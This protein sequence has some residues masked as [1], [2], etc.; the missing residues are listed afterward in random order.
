MGNRML[1]LKV[2]TFQVLLLFVSQAAYAA[3][4]LPLSRT[5]IECIA[6]ETE[7]WAHNGYYPDN[8]ALGQG[9]G[10]CLHAAI[11]NS[12]RILMEGGES[13]ICITHWTCVNAE[14][15]FDRPGHCVVEVTQR[16]RCFGLGKPTNK[17]ISWG[18]CYDSLDDIY[19]N[20]PALKNSRIDVRRSLVDCVQHYVS[21][22]GYFRVDEPPSGRRLK[23]RVCAGYTPSP[24]DCSSAIPKGLAA[25]SAVATASRLTSAGMAF[26]VEAVGA[27]STVEPLVEATC[28]A[29]GMSSE[30]YRL[31]DPVHQFG[32]AVS[33]YCFDD[34]R[35]KPKRDASYYRE[36]LRGLE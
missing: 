14:G 21:D 26:S 12:S 1:N 36:C 27:Y 6:R 29:R 11:E 19:K 24:P 13:K 22:G 3:E 25:K 23:A 34:L 2:G 20:F 10:T 28:K 4:R 7:E 31:C 32:R 16:G 8:H 9:R 17:Y 30:E 15:T 35:P 5:K 18:S 33:R